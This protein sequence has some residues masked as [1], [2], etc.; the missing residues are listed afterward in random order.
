MTYIPYVLFGNYRYSIVIIVFEFNRPVGLSRIT[1][2]AS[3]QSIA[4][5]F[6]FGPASTYSFPTF[7]PPRS[8]LN[9]NGCSPLFL[10]RVALYVFHSFP[11]L[12]SVMLSIT[13]L[14]KILNVIFFFIRVAND[15]FCPF[16]LSGRRV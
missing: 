8:H 12:S 16:S 15:L 7:S 13:A 3:S 2:T 11:L 4:N 5:I 9:S 6:R 1:S 14:S 10:I